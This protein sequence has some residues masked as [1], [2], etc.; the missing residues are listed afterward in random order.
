MTVIHWLEELYLNSLKVFKATFVNSRILWLLLLLFSVF[1]QSCLQKATLNITLAQQQLIYGDSIT[2]KSTNE[3][4][5]VT[6]Q[7][8]LGD[9]GLFIGSMSFDL[10]VFLKNNNNC[11]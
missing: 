8:K 3:C 11:K 4:L 9:K 10:P 5:Y 2:P 7:Q 1:L 6:V